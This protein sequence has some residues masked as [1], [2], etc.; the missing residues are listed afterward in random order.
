MKRQPCGSL[1]RIAPGWE[2]SVCKGS[3]AGMSLA[4]A[5]EGH[6]AG[7]EYRGE[8]TQVRREARRGQVMWDHIVLSK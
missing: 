8:E 6:M 4:Y 3:E 2:N 7:A 1:G 5:R